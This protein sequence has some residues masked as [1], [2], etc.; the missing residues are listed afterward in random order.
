MHGPT[1]G[2]LPRQRREQG[3]TPPGRGQWIEP[4]VPVDED[5]GLGVAGL[6]TGEQAIYGWTDQRQIGGE[7]HNRWRAR[8]H[9]AGRQGR[10][11]TPAR[12]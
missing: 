3:R 5:C 7:H 8:V 12:R 10:D 1:A 6:D 4:A 11:R 9:D 2:W